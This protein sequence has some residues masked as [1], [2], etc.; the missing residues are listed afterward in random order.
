MTSSDSPYAQTDWRRARER[1]RLRASDR[2]AGSA[3]RR[4]PGTW[5]VTK[6]LGQCG[7]P[8][9]R[10]ECILI[11]EDEILSPRLERPRLHEAIMPSLRSFLS[12]NKPGIV[13]RTDAGS[14]ARTIIDHNH[15]ECRPAR[16]RN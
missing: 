15:F 4:K 2:R 9:W 5:D 16:A 7:Q 10:G 13:R 1:R 11:E 14:V 12:V 3:W 8:A 6:S